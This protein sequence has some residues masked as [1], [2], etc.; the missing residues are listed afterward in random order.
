MFR[1]LIPAIRTPWKVAAAAAAGLAI[2]AAATPRTPTA[3]APDVPADPVVRPLADDR[4]ETW[5]AAPMPAAA[6]APA[7]APRSAAEPAFDWEGLTG[8]VSSIGVDPVHASPEPAGPTT[9]LTAAE[10]RAL[11][12]EAEE[13]ASGA[14]FPRGVGV[15]IGRGTPGGGSTEGC[16]LRR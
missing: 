16:K 4:I 12:E 1:H 9:Q 6:P 5:P 11:L 2:L 15:V 7:P 13:T 3:A 8:D 10:A 14:G